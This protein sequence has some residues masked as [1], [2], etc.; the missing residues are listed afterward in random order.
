M[1]TDPLKDRRDPAHHKCRVWDEWRRSREERRAYRADR[2]IR[3]IGGVV[4]VLIVL[5]GVVAGTHL[6]IKI[7]SRVH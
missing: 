7:L 1:T 4:L 6:V 3:I 5:V 2:I